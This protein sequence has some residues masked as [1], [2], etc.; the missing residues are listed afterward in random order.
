MASIDD[1]K[2]ALTLGDDTYYL[3]PTIGAT[4]AIGREL[5]GLVQA[6]A[7]VQALDFDAM[8]TIVKHG[9]QP[10]DKLAK[11]LQG[12]LFRGGIVR[13]IQPLTEYLMILSNG[14]QRPTPEKDKDDGAAVDDAD[15]EAEDDGGN[16]DQAAGT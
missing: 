9:L 3:T 1:G 13:L 11:R 12:L 4:K 10:D 7:K 16:V 2:V 14:G 6:L 5:G 8:H 15:E